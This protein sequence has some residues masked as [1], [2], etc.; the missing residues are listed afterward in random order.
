MDFPKQLIAEFEQEL[1]STRKMLEAIPADA[2]FGFKPHPKSMALGRL[3]GHVIET[4][5]EW[6][7]YILV[8]SEMRFAADHKWDVYVPQ[9]K[10]A[11]LERFDKDSA[12]AVADLKTFAAA[13]W[14][15]NWKFLFGEQTFIDDAKYN[16][17]RTWVV[18]HLV[19]HRAQLGVYLRLLGAP[20]PGVYGPSADE[21]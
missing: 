3:A 16:V 12:K 1:K 9:A 14:D 5:G 17:W 6:A 11:A 21:Q 20:I 10:A 2:D 7:S 4:A 13:N 8:Q 18:N 15:A 19:H